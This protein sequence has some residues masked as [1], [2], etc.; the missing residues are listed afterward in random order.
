MHS[1]KIF[2]FPYKIISIVS[3]INRNIKFLLQS[4][5]WHKQAVPRLIQCEGCVNEFISINMTKLVE[6]P[7]VDRTPFLALVLYTGHSYCKWLLCVS[8]SVNTG[9][10]P[11]TGNVS[12][13]TREN[14]SSR[15]I[16]SRFQ[17]APS[18][19][20]PW[21][22]LFKKGRLLREKKGYLIKRES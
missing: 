15:A 18:K 20:R 9:L 6:W 4:S 12:N 10:I 21:G 17:R 2:V 22:R 8:F 5:N 7:V 19:K 14:D 16:V 3:K 13:R 1:K 11:M